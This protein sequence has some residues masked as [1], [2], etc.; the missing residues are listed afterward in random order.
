[1]ICRKFDPHKDITAAH[2]I[3]EETGW[4]ELGSEESLELALEACGVWAAELA[5]EVEC[6]VL[7]APGTM[8][9]LLQEL[10]FTSVCA[11]VTGRAGRKQGLAT[12]L[13]AQAVA[14]AALEGAKVVGL[15]MFEEGFY[16]RLGFGTG[17]YEHIIRFSP[18]RLITTVEYRPPKRLTVADYKEIHACRL[19]RLKQHGCCS[20]FSPELTKAHML[21]YK[22]GFGLGYYDGPE[23]DLSHHAWFSIEGPVEGG[24]Y[25]VE[26]LSYQNWQQFLELLSVI[27]SLG[28]EVATISLV[29]PPGIQFQN[30]VHKPF[31]GRRIS[32]SGNAE[33]QIEAHANWQMRLTDLP[34]CLEKTQLNGTE[35]HFNCKLNDPIEEYLDHNQKWRGIGG[36]YILT[37]GP[38]SGAKP[39]SDPKLP[40][41][42]AS[43]DAFTRLWLGVLSA[44]AL[45]ATRC[46]HGPPDLLSKLDAFY[47]PAP[48]P[49]WV[50]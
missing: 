38:R 32:L 49:D 40:T 5:G 8:R 50:I 33:Y 41:L 3:W 15:G 34:G 24:S 16:N 30:F 46:L 7:T 1:M 26:W 42:T 12:F 18:S 45:S 22:N 44:S 20:I 31:M 37:L 43:V 14:E 21:E 27:Q 17:S 13:T 48:H 10:P 4:L 11:V 47:L 19:E 23:G 9:Y 36:D 39:G 2:R 25:R 35:V 6:L 29:E 28:D